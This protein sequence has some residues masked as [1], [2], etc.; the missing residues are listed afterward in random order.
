MASVPSTDEPDQVDQFR[1]S[2]AETLGVETL[3]TLSAAEPN[4]PYLGIEALAAYGTYLL[5]IFVAAFLDEF[6]K[7][8]EK[9]TTGAARSLANSFV[10]SVKKAMDKMKSHKLSSNEEQ[11]RAVS[12]SNTALREV[13][14]LLEVSDSINMARA[15]GKAKIVA[16]LRSKGMTE[17]SA[18]QKAGELVEKIMAHVRP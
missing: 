9:E 15:A 8:V 16:E 1:N 17:L 14:A 10:D 6:R 2:L 3:A 18:E 12:E 5:T 7:R 13:S 4:R 11:R